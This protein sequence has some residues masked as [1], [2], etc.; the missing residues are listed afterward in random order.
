MA[1]GDLRHQPAFGSIAGRTYVERSGCW[2]G[3]CHGP[4]HP[5]VCRRRRRVT[6]MR[7]WEVPPTGPTLTVSVGGAGGG[8]PSAGC[9]RQWAGDREVRWEGLQSFI[10]GFESRPT[11][12][13]STRRCY[14]VSAHLLRCRHPRP[15]R[16]TTPADTS[17]TGASASGSGQV[18]LVSAWRKRASPLAPLSP[19]V[20]GTGRSSSSFSPTATRTP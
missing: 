18:P 2:S 11:L 12:H 6:I 7:P 4:S 17:L 14:H 1:V 9:Q 8:C 20:P 5:P 3:P 13:L 16:A 15:F 19:L 10:R